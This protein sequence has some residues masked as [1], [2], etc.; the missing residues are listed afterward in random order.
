M[1][2]ELLAGIVNEQQNKIYAEESQ[3]Q[4]DKIKQLQAKNVKLQELW[5]TVNLSCTPPDNCN[6][7]AILKRYM[8]AC[9]DKANEYEELIE[10]KE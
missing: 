7:P 4:E 2:K 6:D 3:K 10:E 5:V 1:S 8:K 9:L